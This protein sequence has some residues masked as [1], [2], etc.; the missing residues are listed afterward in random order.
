MV[1]LK[2]KTRSNCSPQG[3]PRVYFCCHSDDFNKYFEA[4]ADEILAKQNCS[5][6]YTDEHIVGDENF[7][8][9]LKQ[10]QLFVMPVTTNLLC[11]ENDVLDKEFKFAVENHIPVLPLMQERGLEE[12]FN[13]KCG[14]LQF[15]DKHNTDVTAISYDEKMQKYLESVLI[16]D[17]LA[18]KIRAAFDAYVFLSYRKKDRK[19]A[20]EL[21]RLIH[22]ND[23]CR[24][25]AI[26]YDEFLTPGENFNDSIKE[27][28]QKSELFVLAVTPNLINENNYIMSTEYPMAKQEGKLILPAELVPTDR[29]Q[30]S[31]KYKDIPE[32]SDAY[33]ETELSEALLASLKKMA[34]KEN[35][36][37]PEHNFFIGLAYL[38]GIDVEV[39]HE[40]AVSLITYAAEADLPEAMKKLANMYFDGDSVERNHDASIYWHGRIVKQQTEKYNS[41]LSKVALVSLLYALEDLGEVYEEVRRNKEAVDTY[42]QCIELCQKYFAERGEDIDLLRVLCHIRNRYGYALKLIGNNTESFE[43]YRKAYE[44]AFELQ[45]KTQDD[46]DILRLLRSQIGL[47]EFLEEQFNIDDA[48]LLYHEALNFLQKVK[49]TSTTDYFRVASNIYMKLGDIS[50]KVNKYSDA[51]DNYRKTIKLYKQLSPESESITNKLNVAI[52]HN[53]IGHV[54][55]KSGEECDAT[56]EYLASYEIITGLY[57]A[58]PTLDV[59]RQLMIISSHLA[60]INRN[61]KNHDLAEELYRDALGFAR[62]FADAYA[63]VESYNDLRVSCDKLASLYEEMRSL[64]KALILRFSEVEA[65]KEAADISNTHKN[66]M[67]LTTSYNNLAGLLRM[68]EKNEEALSQYLNAYRLRKILSAQSNS[69]ILQALC[70]SCRCVGELYVA[71]GDLSEAKIYYNEAVEVCE[72]LVDQAASIENFDLLATSY[73]DLASIENLNEQCELLNKAV[74]IY[75]KLCADM[76]DN[77]RFKNDCIA[78]EEVLADINKEVSSKRSFIKKLFGKR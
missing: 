41:D 18:E 76:P 46:H 59:Q 28:L 43:E 19:Y 67:N 42:R 9:D 72:K 60:G 6:W 30:L 47:G 17:E 29:K 40:K 49:N 58:S 77:Q 8:A 20:Q 36:N 27:A 14:D 11:T 50:Y 57:E 25:I 1:N 68:L 66:L 64:N 53:K 51:L 34:V 45:N 78:L 26:W 52:T 35:D 73:V 38:S 3:K 62:N 5:I 33:N 56:D 2:C 54:L 4:L 22:K 32:P 63:T 65:A 7:F 21:M 61:R 15:L 12:L 48:L 24:D 70:Y 74:S 55:L 10:M 71:L 16:G 23:F 75:K 44:V 39:D 69:T 37:S 13:K 31:E